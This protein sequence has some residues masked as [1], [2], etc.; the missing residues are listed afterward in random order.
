MKRAPAGM[1][2]RV[3]AG[4]VIEALRRAAI[5]WIVNAAPDRGA[6]ARCGQIF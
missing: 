5:G 1:V 6:A 4:T 2:A 3:L